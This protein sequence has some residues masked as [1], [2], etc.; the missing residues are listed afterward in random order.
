M[1][2]QKTLTLL[3][4]NI[5]IEAP[6]PVKEL[7]LQ[8]GRR[9][10]RICLLC[11]NFLP[12][13]C[14]PLLLL[15]LLLLQ[16]QATTLG[17]LVDIAEVA[18]KAHPRLTRASTFRAQI[19]GVTRT[20]AKLLEHLQAEGHEALVLGPESGMVGSFFG[21]GEM[22]CTVL[23]WFRRRT[24]TLDTRLWVRRASRCWACTRD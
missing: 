15:P 7:A 9:R 8:G 21:A 11:E 20:L 13:V 12:K 3:T 1:D 19:D 4:Q 16:S 6:P 23:I 5:D 18:N 24:R 2:E 22:Q 10:L 17:A 14:Y